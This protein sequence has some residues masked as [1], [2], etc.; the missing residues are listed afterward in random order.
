MLVLSRFNKRGINTY[1]LI[2][3]KEIVLIKVTN[4]SLFVFISTFTNKTKFV[5]KSLQMNNDIL[6]MQILKVRYMEKLCQI[7]NKNKIEVYQLELE[8]CF[9]CW[10][11]KTTPEIY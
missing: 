2:L 9:D 11:N 3:V 6:L 1:K 7:C 10:M 4:L 5:L 8:V